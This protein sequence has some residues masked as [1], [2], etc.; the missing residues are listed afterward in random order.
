[1]CLAALASRRSSVNLRFS[2]AFAAVPFDLRSST[3]ISGQL[4]FAP[5]PAAGRFDPDAL[6]FLQAHAGFAGQDLMSS[7]TMNDFGLAGRTVGA[8]VQS[9]RPAR[10][11]IGQ[12]SYFGIGEQLDFAHNAITAVKLAGAA[13]SL[14]QRIAGYAPP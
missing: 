3:F 1:S 7:I 5:A 2:R 13:A 14:P 12:Q 11:T 8:A 4:T 10:A 6:A 9:V